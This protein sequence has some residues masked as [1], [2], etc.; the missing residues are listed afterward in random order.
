MEHHERTPA[1]NRKTP[2]IPPPIPIGP[3]A[4][5]RHTAMVYRDSSA[6]VQIHSLVDIAVLRKDKPR[7]ANGCSEPTALDV[8]LKQNE[9]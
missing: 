6:S 3:T 5:V 1:Q 8:L 7:Y 9:N 2:T 4:T